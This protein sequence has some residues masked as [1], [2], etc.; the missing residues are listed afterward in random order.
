MYNKELV[1]GLNETFF[2]S[3]WTPT[4]DV[5]HTLLFSKK[6]YKSLATALVEKKIQMFCNGFKLVGIVVSHL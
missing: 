6:A 4:R 3:S 2:L 5:Y 1:S